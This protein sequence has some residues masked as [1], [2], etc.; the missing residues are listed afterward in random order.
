[1]S[2]SKSKCCYSN[3][4]LQFL[5]C[6]VPFDEPHDDHKNVLQIDPKT[7]FLY[8]AVTPMVQSAKSVATNMT[9]PGANVIKLFTSVSYQFWY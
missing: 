5:K 9:H 1:M 4:C 3:N 7:S 2:L 8:L 6:E